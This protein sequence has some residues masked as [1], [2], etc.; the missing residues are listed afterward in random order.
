[1]AQVLRGESVRSSWQAKLEVNTLSAQVVPNKLR[2]L[3]VHT[4]KRTPRHLH[5]GVEFSPIPSEVLPVPESQ[6]LPTIRD[7]EGLQGSATQTSREKHGV[8]AGLGGPFPSPTPR[9]SPSPDGESSI[10]PLQPAVF[11]IALAVISRVGAVRGHL[12][13]N[14]PWEILLGVNWKGGG[15]Q[16]DG[17]R[18]RDLPLLT[19]GPTWQIELQ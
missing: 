5:G 11:L 10:I 19:G 16:K 15:P 6:Q 2:R 8:G 1:V 9:L 14:K 17:P 4:A 18:Q 12:K 3:A 7:Q 13:L